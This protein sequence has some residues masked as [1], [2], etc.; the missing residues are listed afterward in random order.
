ME[1]LDAHERP[2]EAIRQRYKEYQKL[3]LSD[4]DSHPD[5]IDLQRVPENGLPG[6]GIYQEGTLSGDTL[7]TVFADFMEDNCNENA[8]SQDVPIYA[9]PAVSG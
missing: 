6:G 2:P 1:G 9:H 5:I 3:S 8:H 4:I 7:K